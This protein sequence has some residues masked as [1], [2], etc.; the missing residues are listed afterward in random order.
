M[1]SGRRVAPAGEIEHRAGF[2]VVVSFDPSA[3][4]DF[5][6]IVRSHGPKINGLVNEMTHTVGGGCEGDDVEGEIPDAPG[7]CGDVL[8]TSPMQSASSI[9]AWTLAPSGLLPPWPVPPREVHG[10][11]QV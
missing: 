5:H 11:E 7:E 3:N 8:V 2:G 9:S 1:R 6:V 4:P 10:E